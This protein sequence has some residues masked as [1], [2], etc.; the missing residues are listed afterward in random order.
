MP[1]QNYSIEELASLGGVSRRTVRYYV[2]ES[3]L[4]AP[5]GVGRGRHY[6][7]EHLQRLLRVKAMQEEGLTLED[8]RDAAASRV[9]TRASL[10]DS[11][12]E[13]SAWT[14]IELDDGVELHVAAR[15]RLPSPIKL[16]E[17]AAWC[18]R[19]FRRKEED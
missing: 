10:E 9:K 17:L 7:P 13:R 6:G 11:K 16:A 1:E 2:Q 19:A 8:I 5:L 3:L 14:R 15:H 4:P 18:S 12:A